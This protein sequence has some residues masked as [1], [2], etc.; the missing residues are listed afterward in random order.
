MSH[1]LEL[2]NETRSESS[3]N[4]PSNDIMTQP[5]PGSDIEEELENGG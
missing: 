2:D 3:V 5:L 1:F 4:I